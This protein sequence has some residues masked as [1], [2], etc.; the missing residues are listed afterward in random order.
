MTAYFVPLYGDQFIV[1]LAQVTKLLQIP[2]PY[3][4]RGYPLKN[5]GKSAALEIVDAGKLQFN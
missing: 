2:L 1:R 4:F 3:D 5:F